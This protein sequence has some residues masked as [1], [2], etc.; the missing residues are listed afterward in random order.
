MKL[1]HAAALALVGWYLMVPPVELSPSG[2]RAFNFNAPLSQWYRWD[3]YGTAGECWYVDRD[4]FLRS[5]NALRIDPLN[6]AA[7]A[8]LEAQCVASDDPRLQN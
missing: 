8:Y 3:F 1:R 4:L 2:E 5:E 7:N 6:D